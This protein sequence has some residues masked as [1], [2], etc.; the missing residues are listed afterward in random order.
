MGLKQ[1]NALDFLKAKK[2]KEIT[3]LSKFDLNE[4]ANVMEEYRKENYTYSNNDVRNIT[5]EIEN[6]ALYSHSHKLTRFELRDKLSVI[7]EKWNLLK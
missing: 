1:I 2:Q 6:A 3:L 7:R 4:I 5:L